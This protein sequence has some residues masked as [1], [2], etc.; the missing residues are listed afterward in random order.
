MPGERDLFANFE[1]MRREMEQ[2]FGEVFPAARSAQ[3]GFHPRVDVYYDGDPPRAIVEVE[4]A[5]VDAAAIGLEVT[6]RELVISGV[7]EPAEAPGRV[8][9][10]LEIE[11]GP[12]R[13]TIQLGAEVVADSAT[14]AYDAGVLRIE[15]PIV[16]PASR[17]RS[18]PVSSRTRGSD[19]S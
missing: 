2:L 15:L 8:Y 19:P 16:Q 12:F 18:V 5:G 13:R 14:A 11:R 1:R 4:L 6:G 17:S 9:Q 7:R 10:Q 3:G